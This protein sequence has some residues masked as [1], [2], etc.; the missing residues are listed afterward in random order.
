LQH[1]VEQVV[2][3]ARTLAA[4]LEEK[5]SHVAEQFAP[6]FSAIVARKIDKLIET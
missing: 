6:P 2:R 1:F 3:R 4:S 5:V